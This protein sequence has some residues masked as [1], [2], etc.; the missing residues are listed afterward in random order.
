MNNSLNQKFRSLINRF[1]KKTG[2]VDTIVLQSD[3]L[4]VAGSR[5]D[6]EIIEIVPPMLAS[7]MNTNKQMRDL[8]HV[9]GSNSALFHGKVRTLLV[10]GL[11]EKFLLLVVVKTQALSRKL[12]SYI[13]RNAR[14][15]NHW[16]TE[17]PTH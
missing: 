5:N 3:G 7:I 8:L 10:F 1:R 14:S 13:Y 16:L 2:I 6:A 17:H 9:E 4:F 11:G 15:I 12:K